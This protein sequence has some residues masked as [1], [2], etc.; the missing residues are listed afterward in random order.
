MS[1]GGGGRLGEFASTFLCPVCRMVLIGAGEV[2]HVEE[3]ACPG[4]DGLTLLTTPTRKAV[5]RWRGYLGPMLPEDRDWLV[6]CLPEI[7]RR[8]VLVAMPPNEGGSK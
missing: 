7:P 3:H 8:F 4:L 6:T 1:I 5:E 2:V